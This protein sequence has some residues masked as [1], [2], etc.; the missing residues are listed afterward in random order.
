MC[1]PNNIMCCPG[2]ICLLTCKTLI[3]TAERVNTISYRLCKCQTLNLHD[4]DLERE[5]IDS[6]QLLPRLI[7]KS[8]LNVGNNGVV[9][10]NWSLLGQYQDELGKLDLING[11]ELCFSVICRWPLSRLEDFIHLVLLRAA[12]AY[13]GS[14][15]DVNFKL[16]MS[17]QPPIK[18]LLSGS[19]TKD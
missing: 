17:W 6:Q 11:N 14:W 4:R 18:D 7:G 13:S 19:S 9:S 10:P 3:I 8:N 16:V 12:D 5:N 2:Y 1:K 15:R